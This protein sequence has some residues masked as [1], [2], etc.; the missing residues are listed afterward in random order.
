MVTP[1]L[2]LACVASDPPWTHAPVDS[3]TAAV[4]AGEGMP[5]VDAGG[6]PPAETLAYRLNVQRGLRELELGIALTHQTVEVATAARDQLRDLA[7]LAGSVGLTAD[8]AGRAE[9]AVRFQAGWA[10]WVDLQTVGRIDGKPF[11]GGATVYPLPNSLRL[12]PI[13]SVSIPDLRAGSLDLPPTGFSLDAPAAALAARDRLDAAAERADQQAGMF[14][15]AEVRLQETYDALAE[16]NGRE[17]GACPTS[18]L[19][20]TAH[21]RAEAGV[22]VA[23]RA[24]EAGAVV[25][26]GLGGM[27]RFAGAAA[28]EELDEA[29]RSELVAKW[30]AAR[31]QVREVVEDVHFDQDLLVGGQRS[32]WPAHFPAAVEAL[33]MNGVDVPLPDWTLD[34]LGLEALDLESPEGAAAAVVQVNAAR[35]G[36]AEDR[37]LLAAAEERL[38]LAADRLDA[39]CWR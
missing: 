29:Q 30:T 11:V 9:A 3:A 2:L 27:A 34:A 25:D 18:V 36:V 39:S 31:E 23:R 6:A 15:A 21:T 19:L 16:A 37:A 38:V 4:D 35:R 26:T 5:P 7:Q 32:G 28:E 33:G 17:D 22:W 10:A 8:E 12:A 20:S 24:G 1:L 13:F 14:D